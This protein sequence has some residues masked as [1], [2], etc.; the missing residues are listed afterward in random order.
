MAFH[1]VK[2]EE[3][4]HKK[5]CQKL[6]S[7]LSNMEINML[8]DNLFIQKSLTYENDSET[9]FYS[10]NRNLQICDTQCFDET[11]NKRKIM[12]KLI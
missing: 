2:T 1:K 7:V 12:S 8:R 4:P 10:C 9:S 5:G 3:K 6:S 11:I